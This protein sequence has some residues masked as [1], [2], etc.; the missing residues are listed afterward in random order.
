MFLQKSHC[1]G[2]VSIVIVF[3][4]GTSAKRA[5]DIGCS[6]GRSTF[7]LASDFNEVIGIDYS[8]AFIDCA[9]KLKEKG[10]LTYNMDEEGDLK[11]EMEA[12]IDPAIVR[13]IAL[14]G[15]NSI[16]LFVIG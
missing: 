5:L 7:D 8:Q 4:Q 6:V 15:P 9:S 1:C 10:T 3:T 12:R 13:T 11:Q 14:F 16:V 2:S